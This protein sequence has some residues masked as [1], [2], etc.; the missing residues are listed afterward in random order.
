MTADTFDFLERSAA[1]IDRGQ[2]LMNI[3]IEYLYS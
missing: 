3:I 2:L 1:A